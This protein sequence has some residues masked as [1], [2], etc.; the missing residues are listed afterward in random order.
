MNTD[1]EIFAGKRFFD[2]AAPDLAV[3]DDSRTRDDPFAVG[4]QDPL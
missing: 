3:D 1:T 2:E 4:L